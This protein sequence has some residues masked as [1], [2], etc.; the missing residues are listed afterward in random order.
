MNE[1][2]RYFDVHSHILPG[3]DDG[4]KSMEV[5]IQML[6]LALSQGIRC[7]IATPHYAVGAKNVSAEYLQKVKTQVQEEAY[8][9]DKDFQILLGN[10]LFYS[11]SI[12][13]ALK[14]GEALTLAGSRY[15]LVEFSVKEAYRNIYK[16]MG[17]LVHSGYAPILAHVERYHCL[18]RK[19]DFIMELIELGCYI[20]MNSNS[21]IGGIFDTEAAYNRKLFS[22]GLV[23][24][25]GS[26]CHDPIMRVPKMKAAV[27][28]LRKKGDEELIRQIFIDNPLMIMKNIYI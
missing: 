12:V 18:E 8:R 1:I 2:D 23:H 6:K 7:I 13:D 10:E 28:T 19:T 9:L 11:E 25:V 3:V 14:S 17:Q 4:S 21:L 22:Q 5:T 26:D 20:Q 27:D 16:G 15:V 24:L